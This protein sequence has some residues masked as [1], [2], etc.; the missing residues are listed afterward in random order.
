MVESMLAVAAV[1]ASF[2][3]TPVSSLP[4][5]TSMLGRDND[6]DD[7]DDAASL[8]PLGP[9]PQASSMV[10]V[11]MCSDLASVSS[12][13]QPLLACDDDDDDEDAS[14]QPSG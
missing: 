5:P 2:D 1:V 8:S 10:T 6:D 14:G 4:N 11:M 12:L 3:L 13:P 7:D 9:N